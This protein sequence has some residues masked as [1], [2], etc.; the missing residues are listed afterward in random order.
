MDLNFNAIFRN[1]KT[2]N[3]ITSNVYDLLVGSS[4][5]G[6]G[7]LQTNIEYRSGGLGGIYTV[8]NKWILKFSYETDINMGFYYVDVK[9]SVAPT[10]G[11]V[12]SKAIVTYIT[13]RDA[14]DVSPKDII[15][16]LTTFDSINYIINVKE[17]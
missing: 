15:S 14:I 10:R 13:G 16:T 6:T 1:T 9:Q 7:I 11:P 3:D 5:V 17:V 12:V 4:N 8:N 2:E